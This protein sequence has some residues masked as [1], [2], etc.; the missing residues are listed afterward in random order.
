MEEWIIGMM[1]YWNDGLLEE[2]Q[3][4]NLQYSITPLFHHSTLT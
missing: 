2:E 1:E 3:R 4:R